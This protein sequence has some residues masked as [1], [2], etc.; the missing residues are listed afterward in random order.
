MRVLVFNGTLQDSFPCNFNVLIAG[1]PRV[2][3][4]GEILEEWTA[5]RTD[6]VKRRIFF[7]IQKKEDRLHLLKGLE[8]ILLDIDKDKSVAFASAFSTAFI[9]SDCAFCNGFSISFGIYSG[10]VSKAI[11][12][13]AIR[14]SSRNNATLTKII[15]DNM[16]QNIGSILNR[17]SLMVSASFEYFDRYSP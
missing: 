2:M 7:Q 16:S 17:R 3:G 5:W 10:V 14:Q 6:C 15:L 8:R 9:V 12:I 1:M 4:V 13:M 11:V